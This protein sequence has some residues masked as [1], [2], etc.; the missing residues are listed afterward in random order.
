MAN[1]SITLGGETRLVA[2]L[3]SLQTAEFL[4]AVAA[5]PENESKV[6]SWTRAIRTLARS[7]MNGGDPL[8]SGLSEDDAIQ[9]INDTAITFNEIDPA[10]AAVIELSG[11]KRATAG[12]A[13]AAESTSSA[14]S[15]AS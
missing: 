11:M 8:V 9:K 15:A 13:P 3:K 10:F 1:R 12:E 4:D 14:S 2:P 6:S 7:M 5:A